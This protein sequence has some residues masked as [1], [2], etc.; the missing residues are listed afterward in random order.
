LQVFI[1]QV[2]PVYRKK[3]NGL[4]Q[5]AG[6]KC[7]ILIP[8]M[9]RLF[10]NHKTP[11][12]L[13]WITVCCLIAFCI[14]AAAQQKKTILKGY[15]LYVGALAGG[16]GISNPVQFLGGIEKP[17]QEHLAI[18]YDVHY[19]NTAYEC[20]CDDTYSAG[21]YRSVTP[22]VKIQYNTGKRAGRGLMLGVGLGY[23]FTKDRGKEQSYRLD[24]ETGLYAR[25]GELRDG[26]WDF[27]SIAP[28]FSV[29]VGFRLFR[30]PVTVQSSYYFA[31]TTEGWMAAAGGMG[32]KIGLTRK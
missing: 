16:C 25:L 29:G 23:M 31:K 27:Y 21:K 8:A 20:Y 17:L 15:T 1:P 6:K 13:K 28:S 9:C 18:A 26:R 24:N 22:S 32:V 19:W 4:Q 12:M 11:I 10:A 14:P 7:L 3:Y 30:V 2:L 5:N